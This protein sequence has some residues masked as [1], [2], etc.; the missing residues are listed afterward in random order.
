MKTPVAL[1]CLATL[2]CAAPRP[3]PRPEPRIPEA[4]ASASADPAKLPPAQR[5][6]A[7]VRP[8]AVDDIVVGSAIPSRYLGDDARYHAR[9]VADAQPLEGFLI[10]TPPIW[11]TLEK[12]PMADVDPGP[13][14]S[15]TPML[16]P[17][18]LAAARAGAPVGGIVIE[19]AGIV[20]AEGIGV[21][22]SWEALRGAYGEF[23][24]LRNPEW[25]DSQPTCDAH[26][27]SLPGL[28]F[29]L[30]GCKPGDTP[31]PVKRVL[32]EKP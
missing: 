22:S 4:P 2:S 20:T 1:A 18:A 31:G 13:I 17:K 25:F 12:G 10:G 14:E 21:G 29:L 11:V 28:R 23:E 3:S 30:D 24:L 7:R 32:V 8:G 9:W 15:L 19:H 6:A 26:N 27:K 16:A 5:V